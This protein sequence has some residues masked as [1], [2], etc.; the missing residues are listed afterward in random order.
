MVKTKAMPVMFKL[1]HGC[2]DLPEAQKLS[3]MLVPSGCI[4]NLTR[5]K[6]K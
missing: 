4:G 6:M 3:R 1:M 5:A 2:M